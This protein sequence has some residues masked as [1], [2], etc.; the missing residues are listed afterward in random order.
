MRQWKGLLPAIIKGKCPNCRQGDVFRAL[1]DMY[2]HCPHC[3]IQYE[4]EHGYFAMSIFVG[5]SLYVI[6]FLPVTYILVWQDAPW[7]AYLLMCLVMLTLIPPVF[8]YSRIIWLHIDELLDPHQ[9]TP[10]G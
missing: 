7:W 4:R 5:Y 6:L 2:E 9:T 3:G 10:E 1:F 8:R